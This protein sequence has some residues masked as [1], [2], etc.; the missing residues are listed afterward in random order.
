M[1]NPSQAPR[2]AELLNALE[3][4]SDLGARLRAVNQAR[5]LDP[6]LQFQVLAKAGSDSSSRVRYAAISQLGTVP[7]SD[8]TPILVLLREKLVEDPE[9]DVRAAAA[10]ALGDLKQPQALNDLLIAYHRETEWLVHFSIIAALGELGN[11]D[12]F[13]LLT[14]I[15]TQGNELMRTVAAGAL[16]DLKDPRAVPILAAQLTTADQQLRY[17][18]CLALINIGKEIGHEAVRPSLLALSQDP[19]PQIATQAQ[20]FLSGS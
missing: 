14:D 4:A 8:P 20:E 19:D 18:I 15:L 17:R 12:A 6:E 5:F 13:D 11:P 9:Y 1:V 3:T 2:V 10:A 7:L 16:G